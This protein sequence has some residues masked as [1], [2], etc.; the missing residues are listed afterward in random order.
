MVFENLEGDDEIEEIIAENEEEIPNIGED[1]IREIETYIVRKLRTFGYFASSKTISQGGYIGVIKVI[2]TKSVSY[3]ID[4][5]RDIIAD[6]Y[7]QYELSPIVDI[8][9]INLLYLKHTATVSFSSEEQKLE[10][11][12]WGRSKRNIIDT[13]SRRRSKRNTIGIEPVIAHEVQAIYRSVMDFIAYIQ[14]NF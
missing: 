3:H 8:N 5:S 9:G 11:L 6:I 2:G 12:L 1:K 7:I 14:R 10:R 4:F 13:L